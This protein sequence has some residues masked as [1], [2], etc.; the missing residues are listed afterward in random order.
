MLMDFFIRIDANNDFALVKNDGSRRFA[1][2]GTFKIL[3]DTIIPPTPTVSTSTNIPVPT[4]TP[5]PTKTSTTIASQYCNIH[6][7]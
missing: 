4:S 7:Y 5:A 2:D 3:S 1:A 6:K